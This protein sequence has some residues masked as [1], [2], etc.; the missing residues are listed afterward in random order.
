MARNSTHDGN[1]SKRQRGSGIIVSQTTRHSCIAKGTLL[2][3]AFSRMLSKLACTAPRSAMKFSRFFCSYNQKGDKLIEIREYL[4]K[5]GEYGKYMQLTGDTAELR[6]SLVPLRLFLNPD[7]GGL[8]NRPFH[9][10]VY[11]SAVERD[12]M[13]G[14]QAANKDWIAYLKDV[15][16]TLI[17]QRSHLFKEATSFLPDGMMTGMSPMS[18]AKEASTD[19]DPLYEIRKYQLTLGYDGVPNFM[20]HFNA[21]LPSKIDSLAPTTELCSVMYT[22]IG[23]LNEVIEVWRHGDGS[24]AMQASRQNARDAPEWRSAIGQIANI[25]TSFTNTCFRPTKFSVWQ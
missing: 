10:Y 23:V 14:A 4:V 15:K 3:H 11:E 2:R 18:A 12:E 21:G 24:A 25:T 6:K 5:V 19:K 16:P 9:C 8:L 7:T 13:R 17:E 1:G 22:E 20:K